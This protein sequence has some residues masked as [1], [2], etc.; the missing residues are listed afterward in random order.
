MPET[1]KP[2]TAAIGFESPIGPL[3]VFERDGSIVAVSWNKPKTETETPLLAAAKAQLD[4]Y[5]FCGLRRF[6]LALAPEGSDFERRVWQAMLEIPY[7][8]TRSYGEIANAL[9]GTARD[10]GAACG[11]NPIPIL[12]PCHRV[13]GAGGTLVGYS[14]GKGTETK[15]AL[16]VL[17][18]ALLL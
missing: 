3:A 14:G 11:R 6:E 10:V 5:F 4:G 12:I 18:G 16:L 15:Q 13:M 17:E 2:V 9:G 7:G 8:Q 1:A